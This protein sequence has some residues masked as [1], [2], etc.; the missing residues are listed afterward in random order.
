MG[1]V[2]LKNGCRL[3]SRERRVSLVPALLLKKG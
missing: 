1:H 2:L 3:Y